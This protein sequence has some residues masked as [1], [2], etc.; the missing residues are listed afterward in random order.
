MGA[1][2][3]GIVL[4]ITKDFARL[5]IIAILIAIPVAYWL[6]EG[7]LNDFAYRT[8]LSVWPFAAAALLAIVIAFGTASFQAIRAALINPVDTLRSE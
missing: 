2:A 8:D 4:L 3:A 5:V 6:M 1:S 7:W